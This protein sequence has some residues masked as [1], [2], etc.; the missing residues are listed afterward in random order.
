MLLESQ[1]HGLVLE[2]AWNNSCLTEEPMG[3]VFPLV[4]NHDIPEQQQSIQP[5]TF[6]YKN[7]ISVDMMDLRSSHR[8][9]NLQ[10]SKRKALHR[11]KSQT[12]G[13]ISS[14][15]SQTYPLTHTMSDQAHKPSWRSRFRLSRKSS[16]ATLASAPSRDP[17]VDSLFGS[18]F[19]DEPS[20]IGPRPHAVQ[21]NP[22]PSLFSLFPTPR[23]VFSS[24]G[25]IG[26]LANGK[27]LILD[28]TM[29]INVMY[30]DYDGFIAKLPAVP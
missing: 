14:T 23:Q 12:D 10:N 4:P 21:I 18:S 16:R 29:V 24:H 8:H 20:D 3:L 7:G 9:G 19:Q 17:D 5:W 6:R 30:T 13:S 11:M 15:Q 25:L 22:G 1:A 27:H 2:P 28:S 26:Y